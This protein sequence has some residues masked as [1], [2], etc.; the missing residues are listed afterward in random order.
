MRRLLKSLANH[1]TIGDISTLEDST[2][3]SEIQTAFEELQKSIKKS[4]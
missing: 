3:V 1:E 4:D 2:A